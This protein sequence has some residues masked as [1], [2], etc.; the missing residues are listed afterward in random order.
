[1]QADCA[2]EILKARMTLSSGL[3]HRDN[4]SGMCR[5]GCILWSYLSTGPAVQRERPHACQCRPW[6]WASP[7]S[8]KGRP[9]L[10]E[11]V[12]DGSARLMDGR[13]DGVPQ[14]GQAAHVV[15]DVQ[16]R[17][18]IQACG[19]H[20]AAR[21]PPP[22][23]VLCVAGWMHPP[24][25]GSGNQGSQHDTG[26]RN[27]CGGL[28]QEEDGGLC[29]DTARDAQPAPLAACTPQT[30]GGQPCHLNALSCRCACACAGVRKQQKGAG[31]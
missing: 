12:P 20:A 31:R 5:G 8:R 7:S 27:T 11:H 3:A 22:W 25:A 18:R 17:K 10:V 26:K 30:R 14:R 16:R 29:N 23:H 19:S 4:A 9:D 24:G 2:E 6:P 13:D 21:P 28:V 15:H 1:M